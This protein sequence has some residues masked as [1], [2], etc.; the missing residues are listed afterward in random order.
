M[1][2]V[3]KHITPD[4]MEAYRRSDSKPEAWTEAEVAR[5]LNRYEKFFLLAAKHPEEPIAPTKDI[6]VMWHLHMLSPRFYFEDCMRTMGKILDHDGGFG[7]GEGEMPRLQA[8]FA[9]TERLWQAEYGEPYFTPNELDADGLVN[10]WHDC[11]S[12]CWHACSNKIAI[13]AA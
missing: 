12:R 6:D 4:L 3:E 5:A 1:N 11:Q 10:C 8:T 13:E 7:K 2:L 9:R